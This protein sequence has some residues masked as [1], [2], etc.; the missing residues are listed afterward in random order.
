M[1]MVNGHGIVNDS[2]TFVIYSLHG[3]CGSQWLAKLLHPACL[4]HPA[5]IWQPQMVKRARKLGV[6]ADPWTQPKKY[7][8]EFCSRF[9]VRGARTMPHWMPPPTDRMLLAGVGTVVALYR[10]NVTEQ[11]VSLKVAKRCGW[12]AK[13]QRDPKRPLTLIV[14][15]MVTEYERARDRWCDAVSTVSPERL[16]VVAYEDIPPALPR[17][18]NSLGIAGSTP[19]IEPRGKQRDVER[20]R[21]IIANYDEINR[22][23]GERFGVLFGEAGSEDAAAWLG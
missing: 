20:Y 5:E 18:R 11:M 7:L 10:R 6:M 12:R 14:P 4:D 21:R 3:R 17:L 22:R 8:R 16:V 13:T 1:H 23:M 15:E 2:E 9:G 19:A